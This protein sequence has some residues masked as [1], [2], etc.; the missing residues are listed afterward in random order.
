[1]NIAV[2][3]LG[4]IGGSV[5]RALAG[6]GHRLRG[7]DADPATRAT[8]RTAAAQ[9][10]V[11]ARWQVAGGMQEA[12]DDAELVVVAVPLPAVDEVFHELAATGYTGLVTDV[13]SVK[14]PVLAL[15]NQRLRSSPSRLAGFVGGHPMA[16]RETAGFLAADPD[17][18]TDCAW[19]LCLEPATTMADWLV[20]ADLYTRLGARV[21]P[22]TAA[23]HDQAVAAVS[24][25]PHL[26]AAA[27]AASV[28]DHPLALTL[29][30]GSFRDGTRVA[31]SPPA[32]TASFCAGNPATAAPALSA[33][34][35][36]LAGAT[37]AL[38]ADRPIEALQEWLTAGAT[39]R[40]SWPPYPGSRRELPVRSDA[41]LRLGRAGGWITAVA[42][43]R[44]S[45]TATLPA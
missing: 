31:A 16:G 39:V 44:R 15:A 6:L 1:M 33:V 7:F 3:G 34:T 2:V 14:E 42:R 25:V 32:L 43:D 8:A 36:A 45:V 9:A 40:E 21:V 12:V 20:L 22:A 13:T 37:E 4:L 17:L 26:L 18:F 28:A 29:A 35:D 27:L 23:E 19:V 11:N 5:L 10:P 24:H 30:A 38:G 41:L